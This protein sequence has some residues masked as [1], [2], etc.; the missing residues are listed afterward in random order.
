MLKVEIL[1]Y[2]WLTGVCHGDYGYV[3]IFGDDPS[4]DCVAVA[5][6]CEDRVTWGEGYV[7]LC[8]P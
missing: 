4:A 8:S 6:D 1:Q 2:E 5:S 7:L 3:A